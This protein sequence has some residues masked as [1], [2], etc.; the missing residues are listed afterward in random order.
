MAKRPVAGLTPKQ[1]RFVAEYLID[2][3]GKQAAIRAGYAPSNA[4]ST[5]STLLRD[6]KV[7]QAVAA[8]KA[9]Q[10]AAADLSAARVL[11]ELRRVA[12]L[13]P[14]GFWRPDGTLRPIAEMAPEVRAALASHEVILK[15]VAAG[16]GVQDTVCKIRWADKVRPL[17][18]LAKHFG[19]LVEKIELKETAAEARVARLQAARRRVG[20]VVD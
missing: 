14:I 8:G 17:E 13:D 1:A 5:A 16:D 12:F 4:E 3:N 6:P 9:K 15:N 11:E 18:V 7:S 2:L 19:L 20:D 10:L